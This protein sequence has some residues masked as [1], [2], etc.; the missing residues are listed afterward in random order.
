M[1]LGGRTQERCKAGL[2][3]MDFK[4]QDRPWTE[5]VRKE[6]VLND[7]GAQRRRTAKPKAKK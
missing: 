4:V 5:M 7:A 2:Q 3:E 6:P 1:A